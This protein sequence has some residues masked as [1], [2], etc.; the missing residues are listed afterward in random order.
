MLK[1]N[2]ATLRQV[3]RADLRL[4]EKDETCWSAHVSAAFGGLHS[5]DILK[6]KMR[7]AAKLPMQEFLGELRHRQQNVW[8]EAETLNPREVHKKAVTYHHWCGELIHPTARTPYDNPF[9]A[10]KAEIRWGRVA[11]V[12]LGRICV[13][14][15]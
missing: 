1:S 9:Y 7:S 6:Q 10:L 5:K 3:L 4:A 15:L 14:L 8:R 13:G 2:S 11:H 12:C